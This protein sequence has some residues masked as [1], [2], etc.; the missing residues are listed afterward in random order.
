M[1]YSLCLFYN[2]LCPCSKPGTILYSFI[3]PFYPF[4]HLHSSSRMKHAACCA[5]GV[6]QNFRAGQNSSIS[7]WPVPASKLIFQLQLNFLLVVV[8]SH[9]LNST[10]FYS[11]PIIPTEA[12]G[13]LIGPWINA[14]DDFWITK[15]SS[16]GIRYCNGRKNPMKCNHPAGFPAEPAQISLHGICKCFWIQKDFVT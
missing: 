7:P 2:K 16:A 12:N 13:Q 8:L 14:S 5:A 15:H 9:S 6:S 4:L 11:I 3:L 1:E 10:N